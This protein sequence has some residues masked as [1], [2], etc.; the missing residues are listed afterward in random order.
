ML[1]IVTLSLF[2]FVSIVMLFLSFGMLSLQHSRQRDALESTTL[3]VAQTLNDQDR[4]GQLNEMTACNRE[5]VFESR[6]A[7]NQCLD[8]RFKGMAPLASD[9]LDESREAAD[10]LKDEHQAQIDTTVGQIRAAIWSYNNSKRS[11]SQFDNVILRSS[12]SA[13]Q[14]VEVGYLDTVDSNAHVNELSSELQQWDQSNNFVSSGNLFKANIS[15]TLPYDNDLS[16]LISSLSAPV[17]RDVSPARLVLENHFHSF[18]KIIENGHNTTLQLKHLPSAVKLTQILDVHT[19]TG[20][21]H[22]KVTSIAQT[23]G[24]GIPPWERGE[25]PQP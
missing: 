8:P 22:V 16:F 7:V 11:N 14:D 24:A 21:Q 5:L 9:L 23:S 1:V 13:I 17:N 25:K 15:A 6:S 20:V 3:S 19:P 4:V 12:A 2:L 18:G 10:L